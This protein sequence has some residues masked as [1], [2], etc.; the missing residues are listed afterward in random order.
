VGWGGGA[1]VTADNP[2][3]DIRPASPTPRPD[4]ARQRGLS[5]GRTR[6]CTRTR[7]WGRGCGRSG[8]RRSRRPLRL[9]QKPVVLFSGEALAQLIVC[10]VRLPLLRVG[11]AR[12]RRSLSPRPFGLGYRPQGGRSPRSPTWCHSLL[13]QAQREVEKPVGSGVRRNTVRARRVPRNSMVNRLGDTAVGS[14]SPTPRVFVAARGF[15]DDP[16]R[17]LSVAPAGSGR[18]PSVSDCHSAQKPRSQDLTSR[19]RA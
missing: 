1:A 3:C 11:V 17:L 4:G 14:S 13:Q 8:R 7:G 16:C 5:S 19:Q 15:G 12:R 2:G 6:R 18:G 9:R 10:L